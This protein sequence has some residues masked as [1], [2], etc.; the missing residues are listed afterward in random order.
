MTV[1]EDDPTREEK[2]EAFRR[3]Q[4]MTDDDRLIVRVIVKSPFSP[5]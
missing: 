1:D 3:D 2:I 4:G 5:A